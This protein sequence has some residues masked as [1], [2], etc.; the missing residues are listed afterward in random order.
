ME[1]ANSQSSTGATEEPI[2][3]SWT[4]D[5]IIN[6]RYK[7]LSLLGEGTFGRVLEVFDLRTKSI[8][9]LK[10]V[11]PA[12]DYIYAAEEEGKTLVRIRE[13]DT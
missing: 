8:K 10:I 1:F 5:E 7:V 2:L 4:V 3:Y 13:L 11:M 6:K 9:A 12:Y